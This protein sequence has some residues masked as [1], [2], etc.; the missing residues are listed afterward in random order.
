MK[1]TEDEEAAREIAQLFP[2]SRDDDFG[3][4]EAPDTLD[5][6][7]TKHTV[8]VDEPLKLRADEIEEICRL[9][10]FIV[11]EQ[12]Q[13]HWLPRKSVAEDNFTALLKDRLAVFTTLIDQ[14]YRHCD[15]DLDRYSIGSYLLAADLNTIDTFHITKESSQYDFYRD[16]NISESKQCIPLLNAIQ[17][18]ID[19]RLVDWPDHPTLIQVRSH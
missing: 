4:L 15:N 3:D 13:N 12:A 11:T 9:H 7:P 19:E 10:S 6:E 8:K 5:Y 18:R 17:K 14:Q 2:S 16:T 1:L